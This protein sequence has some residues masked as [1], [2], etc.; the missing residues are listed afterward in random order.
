MVCYEIKLT[1]RVIWVL[2]VKLYEALRVIV[3]TACHQCCISCKYNSFHTLDSGN[4]CSLCHSGSQYLIMY[5]EMCNP[6][7]LWFGYVIYHDDYQ[8]PS[9]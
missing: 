3:V 8:I 4:G 2:N 6:A 7:D 5:V 9:R 1:A